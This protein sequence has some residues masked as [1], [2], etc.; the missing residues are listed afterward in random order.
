MELDTNAFAAEQR[1]GLP[2]D[3]IRNVLRA[4][5]KNGPTLNRAAEICE[6]LDM[7]FYFGPRRVPSGQPGLAEDGSAV[8]LM[9]RKGWLPIPW[10]E[11]DQRP[12]SA[13]VAFDPVWIRHHQLAIERLAMVAPARLGD[14]PT[15]DPRETLA[16]VDRHAS[17]Q[18]GPHLWALLDRRS[19]IL[20][21]VQ[22][23]DPDILVFAPRPGGSTAIHRPGAPDHPKL[24]GR[25][26]WTG[27]LL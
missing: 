16:L 9:P 10:H 26:V 2:P 24:L 13:P 7:E 15:A 23:S 6:A 25:V 17:R 14:G 19:V 21:P 3:S 11:D 12:G 18:G 5:T 22:F 8:S 4:D 20:R 1:A 27:T